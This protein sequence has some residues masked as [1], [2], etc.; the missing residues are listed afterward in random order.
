MVVFLLPDP[1]VSE[2]RATTGGSHADLH[3]AMLRAD[4]PRGTRD[5]RRNAWR[6][7]TCNMSSLSLRLRRSQ[8]IPE[9]ERLA[10]N[11]FGTKRPGDLRKRNEH[12]P[13]AGCY[14]AGAPGIWE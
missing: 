10:R 11:A 12:I 3:A 2:T 7:R 1:A 9:V 14:A 4:A 8:G 6:A 5:A 13:H